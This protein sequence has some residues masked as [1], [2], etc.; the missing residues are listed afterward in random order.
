MYNE[1]GLNAAKTQ[2]DSCFGH[3][4][5]LEKH[6]ANG[7]PGLIHFFH[8]DGSILKSQE[9]IYDSNG[10][11]LRMILTNEKGRIVWTYHFDYDPIVGDWILEKRSPRG[12][13]E[14]R[15]YL[16][17]VVIDTS[18][19]DEGFYLGLPMLY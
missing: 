14:D 13:F 9:Y 10:I 12:N 6:L 18:L 2:I 11:L 4:Y 16:Q 15:I 3:R 8:E 19:L 1:W 17:E 5:R 7:K